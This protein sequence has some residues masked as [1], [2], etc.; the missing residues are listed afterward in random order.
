[1]YFPELPSV[2]SGA[3]WIP[4]AEAVLKATLLLATAALASFI[5][6]RRSAASRHVMWT[7]ALVG[8]MAIPVLSIALPR[9][10]L[11]LVTISQLPGSRSPLPASRSPLPAGS[12]LPTVSSQVE[13][14]SPQLPPSGVL[15]DQNPA[16]VGSPKAAGS[17]QQATGSGEQGAGSWQQLALLIWIVGAAAVLARL[18]LGLLGVQWISR[19]TERV[20]D[21][22]WLPLARSLAAELGVSRRIVFLRSRRASM[23]M[24]WGI[25][26]PAVLM[27]ADADNW[28]AER[29]RIV[30][31][32][33]LA[34]VKRRDCL[35][36]MLAQMSCAV[37]W[38]NPLA[39]I[40]ARHVRTERERACDDLVLAA[41]TPGTA[42]ADQLLEVARVMRADRFPSMLAGAT[43]AMAHRSQLEGRLMAI[44]DPTVPRTGVSSLR[45][46]AATALFACAVMPLASLQPWTIAAAGTMPPAATQFRTEGSTQNAQPAPAPAPAPTPRRYA[47]PD[48]ETVTEAAMAAVQ[49]AVQAG[50]QG[51]IQGASVQNALQSAEAEVSAHVNANVHANVNANVH[52]N[53]YSNRWNVGEPGWNHGANEAQELRGKLA[54]PKTVAALTAALKDTDREVRETALHALVQMRDPSVFDPLV[55]A[56]SDSSPEV[57]EQAAFGLGQLRDRRAV[58]PLTVAL[59]D[60]NGEVREQAVFALG[61]LRDRSAVPALTAAL[62]DVDDDVREQAVF[63]LGQLRDPAAYEGLAVAA[64]DAKADVRQQAVFA[65]GQLRDRRGV[66]PLIS[67]LKD[68]DADVRQQ[69]A[70]ALGQIRDRAAVEA[71]VIALKDSVADV[72]EQVAF[73]L[74]Q[75]RDPRAIDALTAALKDSSADV[76]QQAAFALGQ[77]A[78]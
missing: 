63:A 71:L 17:G 68:S 39:W 31:L 22:P 15:E 57:R 77:L 37:Y 44:L 74:G 27:P 8:A 48:T 26:R 53:I 76:R 73:A 11:D 54:D 64:R 62:K 13:V 40:A 24:A 41:G 20:T 43:L 47:E 42:Y 38:F 9:W 66:E 52:A 35:T 30:L 1:M 75:L 65:L 25:L 55:Q 16:A 21:A 50:V 28:P 6:R 59:K 58:E 23:P 14:A 2:P 67:S 19:R 70:F 4:L 69:A 32:H 3:A 72:R 60:Q 49:S 46:V 10:Q 29:L 45:T 33:E 12:Q 18:G 7:L 34:H 61:Q 5:L 56:L 51:A 78:R 36:H